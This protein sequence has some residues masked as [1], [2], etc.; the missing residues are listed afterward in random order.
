MDPGKQVLAF[1]PKQRS[2]FEALRNKTNKEERPSYRTRK[3]TDDDCNSIQKT[4]PIHQLQKT[5]ITLQ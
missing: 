5:T 4:K 2:K 3:K 1:L